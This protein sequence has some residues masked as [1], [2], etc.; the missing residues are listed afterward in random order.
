MRYETGIEFPSKEKE[1]IDIE[2][3]KKRIKDKVIALVNKEEVTLTSVLSHQGRGGKE[4]PE[5]TATSHSERSEESILNS[6]HKFASEHF[7]FLAALN[8]S[9]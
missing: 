4:S 9:A 7:D 5:S 6:Y 1:E 2:Q 8:K 3:L